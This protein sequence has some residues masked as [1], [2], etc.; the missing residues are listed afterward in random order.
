MTNQLKTEQLYTVYKLRLAKKV[1]VALA[2]TPVEVE[3]INKKYS[4]GKT[5]TKKI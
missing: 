3:Q 2:E 4:G 1:A 5:F